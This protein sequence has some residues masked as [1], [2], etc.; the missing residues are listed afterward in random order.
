VTIV[1][2]GEKSTLDGPMG[3]TTPDGAGPDGAGPEGDCDVRL[4]D[5]HVSSVET[6]CVGESQ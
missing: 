1:D 6:L 4:G 3:A 5:G 2:K